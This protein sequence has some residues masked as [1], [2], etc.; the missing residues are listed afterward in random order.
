VDASHHTIIYSSETAVAFNGEKGKGLTRNPIRVEP[1]SHRHKLDSASRL[2]YAK[3]YTVEYNVKVWFIGKVYPSSEWQLEADYNAF[4]PNL[5][6]REMLPH[7]QSTTGAVDHAQGGGYSAECYPSG[8]YDSG[9]SYSS[10]TPYTTATPYST[11]TPYTTGTPYSTATSYSTATPYNVASSMYK[12]DQGSYDLYRSG[13]PSLYPSVLPLDT[14]VEHK[15]GD[16]NKG[17]ISCREGDRYRERHG[18]G[19]NEAHERIYDEPHEGGHDE[20]ESPAGSEEPTRPRGDPLH[21]PDSDDN[22]DQGDQDRGGGQRTF[23]RYSRGSELR[24]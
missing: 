10:A 3:P 4:H 1:I 24:R 17:T 16:V 13:Y 22:G 15:H 2:N 5:K 11:A 18:Y 12:A 8:M 7:V 9:P 20:P 21:D 6:S 14:L 19:D 23:Q